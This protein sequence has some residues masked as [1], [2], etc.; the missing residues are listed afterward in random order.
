MHDQVHQLAVIEDLI[1]SLATLPIIGCFAFGFLFDMKFSRAWTTY[2]WTTRIPW[3][4]KRWPI[5]RDT[6]AFTATALVA[7][8]LE[9]GTNGL[10]GLTIKGIFHWWVVVTL[11]CFYA[12]IFEYISEGIFAAPNATSV[13]PRAQRPV[14]F[15]LRYGFVAYV[16]NFQLSFIDAVILLRFAKSLLLKKLPNAFT[17]ESTEC[18]FCEFTDKWRLWAFIALFRLFTI[19]VAFGAADMQGICIGTHLLGVEGS[20]C[21]ANAQRH[22]LNVCLNLILLVFANAYVYSN[23]K[24]GEY[25]GMYLYKPRDNTP[26]PGVNRVRPKNADYGIGALTLIGWIAS[27]GALLFA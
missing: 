10:N 5:F 27:I 19:S 6:T 9:D 11:T 12:P 25:F 17:V 7:F 24:L 21:L 14:V 20:V 16:C 26:I 23:L 15:G 13:K 3:N 4:K 8:A 2:L 18:F 1:L 22:F